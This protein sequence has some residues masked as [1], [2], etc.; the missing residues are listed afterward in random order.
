MKR[1]LIPVTFDR[2]PIFIP[3]CGISRSSR[4]IYRHRAHASKMFF[5][6]D[7]FSKLSMHEVISDGRKLIGRDFSLIV[8]KG[9]N[10]LI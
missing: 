10:C 2:V 3:L 4:S 8:V 7:E 5:S 1:Q 6:L 9:E